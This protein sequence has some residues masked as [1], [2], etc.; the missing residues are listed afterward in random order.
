MKKRAVLALLALLGFGIYRYHRSLLARLLKLPPPR[1]AV[2][3][4]R[5]IPVPMPDGVRL[6][7][8]HYFPNVAG[9]FPTILIRT[10]Y[11]RGK[12]VGL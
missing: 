3:V 8:D 11:G 5:N 6:F 2:S 7:T 1:N 12:E 9:D 10:P 4:Q